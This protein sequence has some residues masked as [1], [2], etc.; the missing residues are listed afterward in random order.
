MAECGDS[1]MLVLVTGAGGFLGSHVARE[2]LARG[3]TVRA[4]VRPARPRAALD[5][6]AV[7]IAE[8]DLFDEHSLARAVYGVDGIVHCAARMGYWS[9]QNDLQ[10]RTLIEGSSALWRAAARRVPRIVHVS[11]IAAVGATREPR[12]L[13]EHEPWSGALRDVA[14]VHGKRESEERALAASRGGVPITVVNPGAICGPRRDRPAEPSRLARRIAAREVRWVPRGGVSL[15]DVEDCAFGVAQALERGAIGERYLLG[16]H[17][18]TWR[19]H[20][21]ALARLLGVPPPRLDVPPLAARALAAGAGALDLLR[22]SRPPWTREV[23][24]SWGWYAFANSEKA[25]QQLGHRVRSLEETLAR[26]AG[27]L[28]APL[29]RPPRAPTALG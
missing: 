29:E 9:R 3:H 12:A 10:R 25:R 20:Y 4:L 28:I 11:S 15:V 5:G 22:L 6:L 24:S 27:H 26:S 1:R 17:N 18:L 21:A 19:E 8:G 16:G 2:L 7:E 23:F 13:D 14:Y